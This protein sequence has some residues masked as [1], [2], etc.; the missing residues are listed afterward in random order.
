MNR[1]R[2]RRDVGLGLLNDFCLI[3]AD[4]SVILHHPHQTRV[5]RKEPFGPPPHRGYGRLCVW[6]GER[7]C[8]PITS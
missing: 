3:L 8:R 4:F 7:G 1:H 2:P 6:Y 5:L